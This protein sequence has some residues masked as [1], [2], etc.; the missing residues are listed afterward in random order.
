[1]A[2]NDEKIVDERVAKQ[3]RLNQVD[4]VHYF[5]DHGVVEAAVA[6]AAEGL[7]MRLAAERVREAARPASDSS[8]RGRAGRG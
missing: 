3:V 6:A 4:G 1:M 2:T 8:D 5:D 7:M